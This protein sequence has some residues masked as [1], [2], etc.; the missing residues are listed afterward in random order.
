MKKTLALLLSLCMIIAIVATMG[1]S[2]AAAPEGTAINSAAD[3]AAMAADGTYYLNADIT[4]EATYMDRFTGTLD[5]NGKT[6]TVKAPMFHTFSGSVKNLKIEGE[7]TTAFGCT[8]TSEAN[9][10]IYPWGD[11]GS[12]AVAAFVIA[13]EGKTVTFDGITS[14]AK[15]V[16]PSKDLTYTDA[17]GAAKTNGAAVGALYGVG[18]GN[19]TVTNCVNNGEILG[20]DQVGGLV[21]WAD[22]SKTTAF[23]IKNCVNNGA[24]TSNHYGGGLVGR[25]SEGATIV[26]NCTNNGIVTCYDDQAGGLV[27]YTAPNLSASF[28]N[29]LN[30]GKLADIDESDSEKLNMGGIIGSITAQANGVKITFENCTNIADIACGIE[31]T[32]AG[33]IIGKG[34][35]SSRKEFEFVVKNCVN[36]GN[37]SNFKNAGGVIGRIE[38]DSKKAST[39]TFLISGCVNTG[40]VTTSNRAAGIICES[41]TSAG[42]AVA[43]M[44]NCTNLGDITS[45]QVAGICS[46]AYGS[47]DTS[48]AIVKGCANFGTL[49][50][51]KWI[52]Q[53]LCY[54]NNNNTQ[55]INNLAAGKVVGELDDYAVVVGLS[56]A[57]I[58]QYVIS[59]NYHIENDGTKK[60]SHAD[61]K[62]ENRKAI[63]DVE[64]AVIYCTEAQL[65]SGE[66][67]NALNTA[68][69]A[70][71]FAVENGKTVIPCSHNYTA[72][73]SYEAVAPTCTAAGKAAGYKCPACDAVIGCEEIAA[74]AHTYADGKCTACGVADPAAGPDVS[75]PTGDSAVIYIAVAVLAVLGT[76]VVAKKREN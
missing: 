29:C 58:N 52:A 21:G 31:E 25:T 24:V 75:G 26:E 46:Y 15:V 35:T 4:I 44:E 66:V 41:G 23:T 13:D 17:S 45:A 12:G 1:I 36:T 18:N 53:I 62:E 68:L 8:Q 2:V 27:G 74:T 51:S 16:V 40:N 3:F 10:T 49:T 9:P 28:A 71:V 37:I 38:T 64:G 39:G 55:I 6:V 42:F 59:G 67:A 34:E 19:V 47:G 56:S 48:Y 60:L 61:S 11:V 14:S 7:V 43:T 69:G 73:E 72:A 33:G 20:S 50:S 30:T 76:A 63:A 22:R 65:A 5:G 57:D 54:T 70:T 32:Y